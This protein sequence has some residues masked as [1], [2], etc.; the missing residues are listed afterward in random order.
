MS[1][2]LVVFLTAV[3][4]A[5]GTKLVEQ[6]FKE[7]ADARKAR[8]GRENQA[9]RLERRVSQLIVVAEHFRNI[10]IKHGVDLDK[11]DLPEEFDGWNKSID[12]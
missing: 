6:V 5:F 12:S 9:Y 11:F 2:T 4:T 3:L 10:G 1:T 8:K 7:I